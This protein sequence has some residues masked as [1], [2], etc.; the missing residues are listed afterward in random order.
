M[1]APHH[2]D[3]DSP[4][5]PSEKRT[6]CGRIGRVI[7]LGIFAMQ[8]LT[9]SNRYF[10]DASPSTALAKISDKNSSSLAAAAAAAAAAAPRMSLNESGPVRREELIKPVKP[11]EGSFEPVQPSDELFRHHIVQT[12]GAW[13]VGMWGR[14]CCKFCPDAEDA[15]R[16]ATNDPL[17]SGEP[18]RV[19]MNITYSS[20]GLFLNAN[21]GQGNWIT[22]MYAMRLQAIQKGTDMMLRC[23]DA[24]KNKANHI[25]PW[26]NGYFPVRRCSGSDR[27][28]TFPYPHPPPPKRPPKLLDSCDKFELSEMTP[29]VKYD[30]RRMA[31]AL[32]GIPHEGHPSEAWAE[33]WLW[34]GRHERP[35]VMQLPPPKRDDPPLVPNV[36]V[37]DTAIHFRC[38]DLMGTKHPSFGFMKYTA[39]AR[40]IDPNAA[41]SIGI[42]TNPFD[43][44]AQNRGGT[45]RRAPVRR[46]CEEVTYGLRDFLAEKFPSAKVSLRNGRNE[47]VAT[48]FARLIMANRTIAGISSFGIWP[49]MANFGRGYIRK[50]DYPKAPNEWSHPLPDM[51]D[52]IELFTEPKR[53][54]A[55]V[56]SGL[57]GD[58]PTLLNWFRNDTMDMR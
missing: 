51:F 31:V 34:S 52:D 12:R 57:K 48:A 23:P 42:V 25:L 8:G 47:T 14:Y 28:C 36:E 41:R 10:S 30:L 17:P 53:L 6:A 21:C 50:P 32:V 55:A 56:A 9:L 13:R 49:A 4:R 33:E 26:L 58:M 20:E 43:D 40:R 44:Q 22:A 35:D 3:D 39:Y 5:G 7:I 24:E 16:N 46:A 19:L 11:P 37:D 15:L 29:Y 27:N 54:P 38:E 45:G 18:R 2:P 1:E